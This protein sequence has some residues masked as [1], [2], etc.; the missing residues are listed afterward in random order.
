MKGYFPGLEDEAVAEGLCVCVEERDGGGG[1]GRAGIVGFGN[2]R[3][4]RK[5]QMQP[6]GEWGAS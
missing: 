5:E 2:H 3:I 6:A 1:Q 4:T